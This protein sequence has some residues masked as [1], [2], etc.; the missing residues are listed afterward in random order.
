[1]SKRLS[2]MSMLMTAI[3][4]I[5]N[6]AMAQ[7]ISSSQSGLTLID[8]LRSTLA[9]QP[10]IKLQEEQ[11]ELKRGA[12]QQTAAPFDLLLQ[13]GLQQ[14][15]L[16]TPLD[17]VEAASV[18]V[19][20]TNEL[21]NI[22]DYTLS[23][24]KLLRDGINVTSSYE[25]IRDANNSIDPGVNTAA[26]NFQ[27]TLPLARGRGKSAVD[28]A[29]QAA[30]AELDATVLDL[31]QIISQV[32]SNTASSY[33]NL[34]A[35]NELL[36]ITSEAEARGKTYVD[37]VKALVDAD[38][39]PR[40]DL[41]VAAA[42]LADRA[43]NRVAAQQQVAAARQQLAL[44]MG[45]SADQVFNVPNPA[46]AFPHGEEQ[47][48]PADS[49]HALQYYLNQSL[50]H[51]ADYLA[52]RRRIDESQILLTG[53]K[54]GLLP[55]V[56]LS[57]GVGY[58]GL[59]A[60]REYSQYFAAGASNVNG[61]NANFGI[62]FSFPFSNSYARGQM[63]QAVASKHQNE[64]QAVQVARTIST[65]VVTATEA[66]RNAIARLK[67]ARESVEFFQAALDGERERYRAGISSFVDVLTIED[68][69]TNALTNRVQAELSYALALVQFRFATGTIVAPDRP[70]QTIKPNTLLTLPFEPNAGGG[71]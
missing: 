59:D 26:L 47:P 67:N 66:V 62:T 10:F 21:S 30:Y 39:V 40:S 43:S 13:S 25:A 29:E 33:W 6:L 54:N 38:H 68:R 34:V 18:G 7:D 1:L 37:N 31:N 32:L 16:N 50:L 22:T 20:G 52:A 14:N 45:I 28:A 23:V 71:Q 64:L 60:S 49:S 57:V 27:V 17:A 36:N 11:V 55:Q 41:N 46:D 42:N 70:I 12:R 2:T 63:T 56:N 15:H 9:K 3:C 51:R 4:A 65:A 53:A 61:P 44:D 19:T 58:A 69:L 35:A 5:V 48:L 8:A 24:G